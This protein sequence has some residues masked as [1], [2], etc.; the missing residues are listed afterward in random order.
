[1]SGMAWLERP[2]FWQEQ[3][4]ALAARFA[5]RIERIAGRA[6]VLQSIA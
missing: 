2:E 5:E 3:P 6:D 4:P 1:L